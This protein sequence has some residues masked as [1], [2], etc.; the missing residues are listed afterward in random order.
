MIREAFGLRFD[1][2]H[3]DADVD[4]IGHD[5]RPFDR[6]RPSEP[7]VA[8]L[9]RRLSFPTGVH[10][11]FEPFSSA[12]K[13]CFHDDL[14]RHAVHREIASHEGGIFTGAIHFFARESDGR[15]LVGIEE[16]VRAQMII[17]LLFMRIDAGGLDLDLH[18]RF[19]RLGRIAGDRAMHF[20]KTSIH[21][22]EEMLHFEIHTRVNRVDIV[23]FERECG[24]NA[25]E[26]WQSEKSGGGARFHERHFCVKCIP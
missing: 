1:R 11:A 17:A 21:V 20:I 5:L 18:L 10:P 4:V 2:V 3:F 12:E 14:L 7:E 22:A 23:A 9:Q 8:P 15:I 26:K 19:F 6:L 16:G 25:E 13:F 24:R